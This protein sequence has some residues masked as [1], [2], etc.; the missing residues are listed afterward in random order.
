MILDPWTVELG[1]VFGGATILPWLEE[2]LKK[3]PES[4]IHGDLDELLE[5]RAYGRLSQ[6]DSRS[7]LAET[8]STG[9]HSKARIGFPDMFIHRIRSGSKKQFLKLLLRESYR[10]G[11]K[12]KTAHTG[13]PQYL[14]Q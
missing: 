13:K 11:N 2:Q 1:T 10:V 9:G 12:S 5:K 8:L 3:R 4:C 14:V 6:R 7:G